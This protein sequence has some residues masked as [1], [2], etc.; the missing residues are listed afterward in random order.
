MTDKYVEEKR[1]VFR[2]DLKIESEEECLTERK[3]VPDDRSQM[4]K[5]E[6]LESGDSPYPSQ[7]YLTSVTD[8]QEQKKEYKIKFKLLW[9]GLQRCP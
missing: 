5:M 2:F 3:R 7:F 4:K 1:W 6:R 9:Y 8:A